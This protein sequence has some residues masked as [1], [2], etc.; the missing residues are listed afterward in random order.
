MSIFSC[1]GENTLG[2]LL[3]VLRIP[4]AS[5]L[6]TLVWTFL[7]Q[8]MSSRS[9]PLPPTFAL[10]FTNLKLEHEI[11]VTFDFSCYSTF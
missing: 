3:G 9:Q 10:I 5:S 7:V 8:V 2:E 1:S 4:G 11:S 6:P